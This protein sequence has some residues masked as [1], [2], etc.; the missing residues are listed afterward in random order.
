MIDRDLLAVRFSQINIERN[1]IKNAVVLGSF[2]F[3]QINDDKYDLIVSNI[4]ARIGEDAITS[5][6]FLEPTKHL[7]VGGAYWFVIVSGLNH[8]LIRVAK[9]N[10]LKFKQIRKRKGHMVYK[11]T[12]S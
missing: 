3:E 7:N 10:D 6:F 11:F 1:N 2:G 4:P 12:N 5:E 9:Q 8:L